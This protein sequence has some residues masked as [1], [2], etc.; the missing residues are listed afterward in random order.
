MFYQTQ[1][2]RRLLKRPKNAVFLSLV[3]LT[4]DPDLQTC[5][6]EGFVRARDQTCLPCEFGANPFRG[7]RDIS[8]TNKK[9]QTDGAKSRTFR[10]SPH[11]VISG[12]TETARLQRLPMRF[13]RN[14][15]SMN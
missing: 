3:T 9:M 14:L 1:T 4:F 15:L 8:Y 7:S 10:S 11:V 12:K 6:S 2:A 13:S 5:P